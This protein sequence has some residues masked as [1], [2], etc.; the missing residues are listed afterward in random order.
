MMPPLMPHDAMLLPYHISPLMPIIYAISAP[1]RFSIRC[2]RHDT[3]FRR[4]LTLSIS[5][6]A[7]IIFEMIR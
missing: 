5:A 1:M 7:A 2:F 3:T 6:A 4:L